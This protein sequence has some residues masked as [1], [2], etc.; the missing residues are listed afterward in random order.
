MGNDCS[1]RAWKFANFSN[2]CLPFRK[3]IY[4]SWK[5][6]CLIHGYNNSLCSTSDYDVAICLLIELKYNLLILVQP[7]FI[8]QSK[9]DHNSVFCPQNTN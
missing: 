6:Y 7:I 9:G 5:N 1:M 4:D 8:D 2:N 3:N